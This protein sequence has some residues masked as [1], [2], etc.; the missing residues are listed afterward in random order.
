LD[1]DGHPHTEALRVTERYTRRNLGNMDVDITLSDPAVYARPWTVK[2]RAELA[3]D[4]EMIEFVCAENNKNQ[5]HWIGKAS[6]ETKNVVKVSP[7]IL[8]T[9]VGTF[10]EQ[11]RL[12][13][14]AGV[15][16]VVTI[17][18]AGGALLGDM[19]GRGNTPLLAKSDTEFS[20]L[21]GLNVEFTKSA[22]GPVEQL[23]VK[24]VSG[25]YR[26]TRKK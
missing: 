11:P 4:T 25:N 14:P 1:H 8:A 13:S 21:Y 15:P 18:V 24:H 12:W 22:S 23:F 3:P 5:E 2:V 6:D 10:M 16:R 26:F 19:D 9:Y 7:A 17:S 20:G